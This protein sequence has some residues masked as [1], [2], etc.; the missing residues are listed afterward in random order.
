MCTDVSLSSPFPTQLS[1]MKNFLVMARRS[2]LRAISLDVSYYADVVLPLEEQGNAVAV[3]VDT[4][5][6]W[7]IDCGPSTF[8]IAS[9]FIRKSILE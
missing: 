5:K 1:E 6:S 7:F 9:S 4:M 2:D 3:D 8:F